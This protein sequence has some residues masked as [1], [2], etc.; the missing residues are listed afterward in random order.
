MKPLITVALFGLIALL[1]YM[2]F[3][4]SMQRSVLFPRP[5]VPPVS[6]AEG[7]D[8]VEVTWL[9]PDR[10]IEAWYLAPA[11][12]SQP[13]PALIFAHGNGELIDYWLDEFDVLRSWGLAVLLVEYPGY[14][15]SRGRPTERSITQAMTAAYDNLVTRP[16]VDPRRIVAYGRSVGGGP[17][18]AL[19]REREVAALVLES[20]FTS[21]GDL[22]RRFGL[23][24][25]LVLD[26]FDNLAAVAE[27]EGP[28]LVIHGEHDSM[29]PPAH[30]RAL[31]GSA[32]LGELVLVDCGHNDCPRPWQIIRSFLARHGLLS[33]LGRDG[34][35][36]GHDD[37]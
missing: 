13:A 8:G 1:G 21:V 29:I 18:C 12:H 26:P 16:E 14:G 30:G 9:G 20:A 17:A 27:F 3:V 11:S 7:R 34:Y 36:T 10:G 31:A 33:D 24:G 2:V 23:F 4:F 35:S 5:P 25:P 28:V 32:P 19:T 15:R 6:A 22:A 37:N